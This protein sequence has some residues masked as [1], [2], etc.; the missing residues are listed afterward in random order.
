MQKEA[1]HRLVENQLQQEEFLSLIDEYK[2]DYVLLDTQDAFW[3][4]A[5]KITG[6]TELLKILNR[7]DE[8]KIKQQGA[9]R[10]AIHTLTGF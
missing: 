4:R 6:N 8:G 10:R 7:A 5:A 2:G 1:V 9:L 3:R